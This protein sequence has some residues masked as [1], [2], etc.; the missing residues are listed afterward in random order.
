MNQ[1]KFIKV[2]TFFI[3]HNVQ[4]VNYVLFYYIYE[5]NISILVIEQNSN[6]SPFLN[7][8]KSKNHPKLTNVFSKK[9]V[10]LYF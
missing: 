6:Q 2:K 1:F 10:W 9:I 3:K 8:N 4:Y 7:D 5:K